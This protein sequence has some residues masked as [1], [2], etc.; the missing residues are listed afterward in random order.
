MSP[1]GDLRAEGAEY[2]HADDMV[3]QAAE[4]GTEPAAPC[5][6]ASAAEGTGLAASCE[7]EASTAE[8][9]RGSEFRLAWLF[10]EGWRAQLRDAGDLVERE[11]WEWRAE[12]ILAHRKGVKK[13]I[14]DIVAVA[15]GVLRE[16]SH[17]RNAVAWEEEE[18]CVYIEHDGPRKRV[19]WRDRRQ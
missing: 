3:V 4:G 7:K 15:P 6:E 1:L 2:I 5:E 19:W 9:E 11:R 17:N 13:N 10:V 16:G 18:Q 8:V 14:P 12:D